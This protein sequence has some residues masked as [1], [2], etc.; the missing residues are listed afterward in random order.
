MASKSLILVEKL[1]GEDGV[2]KLLVLGDQVCFAFNYFEVDRVIRTKCF[3]TILLEFFSEHL[4][5]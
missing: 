2:K 5:W 4:N 1:M 3:S